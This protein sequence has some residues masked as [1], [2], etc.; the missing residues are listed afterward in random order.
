MDCVCTIHFRA[1]W[2]L[3]GL[4]SKMV[5]GDTDHGIVNHIIRKMK[6]SYL[7][8]LVVLTACASKQ[9]RQQVQADP[10]TARRIE[11]LFLGDHGHHRPAERLPQLMA[12]LGPK[13][14]NFTY[15][16][17][18]NDLNPAT[19]A[20]YDALM[21]FANWDSIAP[22]QAEALLHFVASGKGFIP[23]HCASYCFRNN[24]DIVKL[25]GGQFWRHTWDTIQPVWTQPG[26]PAIA[27]T[28]PFKTVDETYV[29][30]QLQ[31]DNVVLTERLIGKDQEK[32]RPGQ[33]REP[34]TW[35]RTHGKGRVFYT[36]Y[37]HDERTWSHPGFHDLLEK[38]ILWAINDEARAAH[39]A[40]NPKPF[41]YREARLPNYEQR[42]GPQLQ[43]LPLSPEE[44]VKHIQIPVDF[45]LQV[46]A[47]EPD[48]MHPIAMTWDERGR[49]FVLITKD[50]PNE[51]KEEGGED[52]IL[53][54]EDTDND[55]KADKFTRFAEGLS[56]PT[57]MVFANGGLIV[58][59]APHMLFLQDTDGDD[60]ADVKKILFSGFGTF[61]T[62]AGPSSLHYG[63]DNWI[64]GA[65]GYSGFKGKFGNADSLN[66]GQALFRFRPD[67]SDMELLTRTSNNTWGLGFNEEG[68]LFGSTANNAHGW[69]MAIPNR[70]FGS[71]TVDNG[72]R[73]TD[74]H[75]DMQPITPKVRQVDVFGGFTAAAGHNFYT[76][77]AFPPK[78][79][80]KAAFVSEP[81]GHLLH[82]NYM[83][84]NGT[85]Y[86]DKLGFNLLA[87]ADEWVSPVFAQVGPDGAVWVADWYSFI[88]QHNPT[89]K[90]F[91]NGPGNAYA[92]DLRDYT[93][94]RIYR[95]GW[96]HAPPYQPLT[97]HKNQPKALVAALGNTNMFWRLQAQ[98]L[99]VENGGP[100][101]VPELAALVKDNSVD[102]IGLNTA[103]I[104]ALWTLHGLGALENENG[105]AYRAALAALRHPSA[106]VRK[107]ALRVLPK[108]AGTA[109]ALLAGNLLQ[110]PDNLVVLHALLAFS[111]APFTPA[112][113]TA[114]LNRLETSAE[115]DDRWLP[116][117]FAIVLNAHDGK[118]RRRYLATRQ[119][120]GQ[121]ALTENTAA[122]I[123]HHHEAPA[124]R[125]ALTVQGKAEL[126]V[127]SIQIEP[128][129][130]FVREYARIIV[131]ITN[132]GTVAV[133]KEQVPVVTVSVR[134]KGLESDFISKQLTNGIAPGETVRLSEGN[135]GPWKSTFGFSAEQAGSV[136][137][138][139]VVDADNI[140]PEADE[141]RNNRLSKSFDVKRPQSLAT[142]ALERA[143]R[144]Y[145]SYAP[146]DSVAALFRT[147]QSLP[148][149]EKA[150]LYKGAL[151]GWN[152]R[153]KVTLSA[154]DQQLIASLRP[155]LPSDLSGRYE[156]FLRSAGMQSTE[157]TD[158]E[159][160]T[161]HIKAIRE[162]M[163][164]DRTTFTVKAGKPVEIV[165]ENP[166]AMQHNLVIG[167]PRSLEIIG[168]AADQMI[169]R[170][171]AAEKQY[172][173]AV[174][175]VIAFTPLV[176]PDETYR[177]RF[178]APATPGDYP[179]VCTFPGHWRLMSGTMKVE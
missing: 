41:E 40:L 167:K 52:Y 117:A 109:E 39:T 108:T 134:G 149:S 150:A 50:Y 18:L 84:K 80:N 122:A 83:E 19:L 64:Y 159:L 119:A 74:T 174:P 142:W 98:R 30:V 110:D 126:S 5:C 85:D 97:L 175:E 177:L 171:D 32:D 138:T 116:D 106:A 89:P 105:E 16:D 37:G 7:I 76:A 154:E 43:Q 104:H 73:S 78:F 155:D 152:V 146:A 131:E 136:T 124:A 14:I 121:A 102:A 99:L 118:L 51:R 111:E 35:V 67:G 1:G 81:T 13:G 156:A 23:V 69:Y 94:G 100:E 49:L 140:I 91:E 56:I 95:I 120:S 163:K 45:T 33:D 173:P 68:D 22:P 162:E 77:R 17:D 4:V 46:F 79:W 75:K 48:V 147:A 34:Y 151:N 133:P 128:G 144:G 88:I 59:Q 135:N 31:P 26:H 137:V 113:E 139:A 15:T 153:R 21:L 107:N 178:T 66:F 70:Y 9:P 62:H 125:A 28:A 90:G 42:P 72:S 93:H 27:G 170:P 130:P 63:F 61:D 145:A 165:F 11:V 57:G 168:N 24:P 53:L 157:P 123:H 65:V 141:E 3:D 179:Y 10:L 12:A 103:A 143:V 161:I 54:C 60:K 158:P 58:S 92:T 176:N 86:T 87:G 6:F 129:S 166:D 55:G 96:K 101:I 29:H 148:S 127:S 169:T 2:Q 71:S 25:M 115:T 164:Y 47:H 160:Q 36:A 20:R 38:G 114:L 112:I 8:T 172:V 44:S 82:I 132:S